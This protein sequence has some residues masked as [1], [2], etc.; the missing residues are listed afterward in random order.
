MHITYCE[1]SLSLTWL[2]S[3]NHSPQRF[4][5]PAVKNRRLTRRR[6]R[7]KSIAKDGIEQENELVIG[8]Y[9]MNTVYFG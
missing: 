5:A 3:F 4:F 8:Q 9:R 1:T 7:Y 6:G 2:D